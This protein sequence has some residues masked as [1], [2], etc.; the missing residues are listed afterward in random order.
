MT[1]ADPSADLRVA[2]IAADP[3]AAAGLANLLADQ[4]GLFLIGPWP[5]AGGAAGRLD[6]PEPEIGLL[7]LGWSPDPLDADLRRWLDGDLPLVLLAADETD[8]APWWPLGARGVIER[9]R[10]AEVI[11]A[12]LGAASAGLLVGDPHLARPA[13]LPALDS[14]RIEGLTPR[15]LEVLQLLADGRTN[16]AIAEALAISEHTVKFHVTSILSKLDAESRT[17]A[18]VQAARAGLLLL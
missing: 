11:A 10:S 6:D 14:T 7:D 8:A 18:A 5:L 2:V 9:D 3:L 13:F 4:P 12:A 16:R 17:A 15:E 1:A